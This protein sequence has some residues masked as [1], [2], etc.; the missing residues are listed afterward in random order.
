M[1]LTVAVALAPSICLAPVS[2]GNAICLKSDQKLVFSTYFPCE[3]NRQ[4][5]APC[6]PDDFCTRTGPLQS[7][8]RPTRL[9]VASLPAGEATALLCVWTCVCLHLCRPQANF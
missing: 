1:F 4:K 3:G 8:S 7:P 6:G 9:P 5:P 2:L